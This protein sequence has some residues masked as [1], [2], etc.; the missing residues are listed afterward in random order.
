MLVSLGH[1]IQG[2]GRLTAL[3]N[4]YAAFG[5]AVALFSIAVPVFATTLT[6][7][8]IADNRPH[9]L[10]YFTL[11]Q[12]KDELNGSMVQVQPNAKG[13]T[14]SS[15][16]T[17]SGTVSDGLFVLR[18]KL[19]FNELVFNGKVQNGQ[20]QLSYTG[21]SGRQNTLTLQ[22]ADEQ[23]F[24]QLLA[25]WRND[26]AG[27][28]A[29][30]AKINDAKEAERKHLEALSDTLARDIRAI[31]MSG[32]ENDIRNIADALADAKRALGSLSSNLE[33]LKADAAVRPM[34][35][36]QAYQTVA[37]DFNQTMGFDFNQSLGS[38]INQYRFSM[39]SMRTRLNNGENILKQVPEHAEAL[40]AAI[41]SSK[42]GIRVTPL[43]QEADAPLAKYKE[44]MEK[45]RGNMPG[46]S[47]ES[48]TIVGEAKALMREGRDV[49]A[50]AQAL[51]RC[52]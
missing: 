7:I 3:R 29:V 18:T 46:W 49:M 35:C 24:N 10:L 16:H 21:P 25:A 19:L 20:V 4:L 26:L 40:R 34:T 2:E 12:S 41:A 43:P 1:Y 6:G 38:A 15:S 36:Y 9:E 50:G 47:A 5:F 17:V 8:Y 52:R 42:F 51:V 39:A 48:E 33:R 30:Q 45:A 23:K 14:T 27:A 44:I 22:P 13:G 32:I 28:A 31:Q 11:I 37:Y